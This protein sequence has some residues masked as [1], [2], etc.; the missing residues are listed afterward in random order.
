MDIRQDLDDLAD[1]A[2]ETESILASHRE[3]MD[4]LTDRLWEV[5]RTLKGRIFLLELDVKEL[6]DLPKKPDTES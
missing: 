4:K 6:K 3:R 1:R 5:E 2:R